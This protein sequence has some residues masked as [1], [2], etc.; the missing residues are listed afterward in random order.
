MICEPTDYIYPLLADVYYPIV[1]Q[2]AYGNVKKTWILD[3]TIACN[4]NIVGL[5]GREEVKPNVNITQEN[6]LL[7]RTKNDIR[8]SDLDVPNAI[9]NV[10][11]SNI[12]DKNERHIYMETAGARAGK[13]TIYEIASQDPIVGAFGDVEY[14]KLVIKRSENQAV[15][16]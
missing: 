11:I 1:E 14:Y 10:I 5:A 7:G 16:V 9:T 15:D 2:G 8:I 3:K 12:R 4:F 6:I 13:S